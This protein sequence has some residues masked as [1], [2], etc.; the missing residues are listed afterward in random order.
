MDLNFY[1]SIIDKSLMGYAY[2]RIICN[3]LG[4][5]CDYE[6]IEVND[7]FEKFTGLSAK[8]VIGKKIT[9]IIPDID[10]TEFD[11]IG[12]YGD[13]A[14][15]GI[16]KEIEQ[17]SLALD[18]YYKVRAFSPQKDYF[19]VLF[20]D[21]TQDIEELNKAHKEA[22]QQKKQLQQY[23]DVAGVMVVALDLYGN[24]MLVNNRACEAIESTEKEVLGKNWFD[25]F[26]PVE[27]REDRRNSFKYILENNI[28]QANVKFEGLAMTLDKKVKFMSWRY[29]LL[30]EED[31]QVYGILYAGEDITER[32]EMEQQLYQDKELIEITLHSVGD[33]IIT[34]DNNG[35]VKLVNTVAENLTGYKQSEA[36]NKPFNEIFNIVNEYTKEKQLS[37]VDTVLQTGDVFALANHTILISKNNTETPIADSAAPIKDES[38]K[39]YGIVLVF[40]DISDVKLKQNSIQYLSYH[41]QLTGLC[42]RRYFEQ[43]LTVLDTDENFPISVILGDVN[44]LK[45]TN[46]AFGHQIG[47]KLLKRTAEIFDSLCRSQDIVVRWGGDEFVILLPKTNAKGAEAVVNKIKKTL[48]N[49][50]VGLIP[51]SV[52]LGY[53]TKLDKDTTIM[54]SFKKAENYM[55]HSKLFE[56]PSVRGNTISTII[57]T[58]NK[59]SKQEEQHSN[60]VSILCE[61]IAKAM[62]LDVKQIND[63]SVAGLLHDIGNIALSDEIALKTGKLTDE[64]WVEIKRHPE[65]GYRILS[66]VNELAEIADFVLSHHERWDGKGYPKG[67]VGEEIPLQS[68]IIS[69]VDAFDAMVTNRT[70]REAYTYELAISELIKSAGTQFDPEIVKVFQ[71][72]VFDNIK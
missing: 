52:S 27:H 22:L 23:L 32:K 64:D 45:L 7:A 15:N 41:D 14:L 8:Q 25:N 30:K 3:E 19:I 33:G 34:T 56:S 50:K 51:L 13:V 9:D 16:E 55:Y 6:F 70:Y 37:P 39:I 44:G 35:R 72:K 46:D 48:R 63:I 18:R 71:E 65:I 62:D 4:V 21:I 29:S 36:S 53:D 38:G 2:H 67:L 69:V 12:F 58:L 26:V 24:I 1:K 66:S 54:E 28:E 57:N 42:N 68:R 59:K 60:R 17:F 10:K 11:W 31:G 5:P 40:R 49:A 20:S 61:H 47:D 43:Q